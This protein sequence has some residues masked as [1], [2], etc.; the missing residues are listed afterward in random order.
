[1]VT[2]FINRIIT[3]TMS[4]DSHIHARAIA[5]V[6]IHFLPFC[7]FLSSAHDEN[8]RNQQYNIYTKATVASI[9]KIQFIDTCISLRA[10][11]NGVV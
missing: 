7:E 6:D 3:L 1:M 11:H 4:Q 10:Y 8:T 9:P 2:R 5:A